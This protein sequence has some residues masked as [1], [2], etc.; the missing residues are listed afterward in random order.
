M[1][2]ITIAPVSVLVNGS[3][4]AERQLSVVRVASAPAITACLNMGGK[5]G[6]EIRESGAKSGLVDVVSAA[7]RG[8]YK[9]LAEMLA[10]RLGE[11][12]LISSRSTFEAL[13]DMFAAR[14]ERA[15]L[16]KTGGMREDKKS[17]LMV[18]GASLKLAL[19]MHGL[20]TN[21]VRVVA[22]Y[23]AKRKA[24]SKTEGERVTAN[25]EV[26]A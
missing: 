18:P 15:K 25:T 13:P 20:V 26:N 11:P 2:E 8:D 22:E 19:E 23:H 7:A 1:N 9:P 24:E 14:V 16:T 4:K 3:N 5:V 12:I 17:G 21:V 10:I 6:K